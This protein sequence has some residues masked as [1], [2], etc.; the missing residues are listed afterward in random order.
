MDDLSEEAL[1]KEKAAHKEYLD[2]LRLLKALKRR[3]RRDG[4]FTKKGSTAHRKNKPI[5]A[6]NRRLEDLRSAPDSL[7]IR[8]QLLIAVREKVITK[9]EAATYI[10]GLRDGA[11]T[12]S[13]VLSTIAAQGGQGENE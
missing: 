10:N 2:R 7:E 13:V 1:K 4:R 12:Q 8:R 11:L 3:P 6:F 9:D 5:S